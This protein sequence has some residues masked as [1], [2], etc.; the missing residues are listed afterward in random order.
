MEKGRERFIPLSHWAVN[1]LQEWR[2]A[3]G[4]TDETATVASSHSAVYKWLRGLRTPGSR[5]QLQAM[6]RTFLK[7][8]FDNG[9]SPQLAA[10][11]AGNSVRTIERHYVDIG[12]LIGGAK[13]VEEISFGKSSTPHETPHQKRA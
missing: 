8:L 5:I 2:I 10:K 3:A 6:R 12:A 9:V 13:A 1:E 11:L 4:G 7:R